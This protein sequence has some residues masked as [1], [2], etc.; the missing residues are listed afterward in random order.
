MDALIVFEKHIKNLEKLYD[1][2][3]LN[4]EKRGKRQER[5]TREAFQLLLKE[6]HDKGKE[7]EFR[8]EEEV[9]IQGDLTS[10]SLWSTLYTTIASDTRFDTMLLQS[11]STPLDLFKFYVEDLKVGRRREEEREKVQFL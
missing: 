8:M 4:E 10:V 9:L 2:E 6:L 11:G 3:K 7:K 5:K 1:E